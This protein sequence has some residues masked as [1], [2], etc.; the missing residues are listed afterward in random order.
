MLELV[1]RLLQGSVRTV[2][3]RSLISSVVSVGKSSVFCCLPDNIDQAR[4]VAERFPAR[5]WKN[6]RP[7]TGAESIRVTGSF[8]LAE[9]IPGETLDQ[10]YHRADAACYEAK[11]NGRNQVVVAS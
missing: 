9:V 6:Q 2:G 7:E 5:H 8:G 4:S 1:G 3:E 11:R 10:L